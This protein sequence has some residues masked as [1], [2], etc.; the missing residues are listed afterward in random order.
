MFYLPIT[1][2]G[3]PFDL[4]RPPP[5][6]FLACWTSRFKEQCPNLQSPQG[7][8]QLWLFMGL[9]LVVVVLLVVWLGL[10]YWTYQTAKWAKFLSA[11]FLGLAGGYCGLAGG[12]CYSN[13]AKPKCTNFGSPF[14][15]TS[16]LWCISSEICLANDW[17]TEKKP[18]LKLRAR[19]WKLMVEQRSFPFGAWRIFRAEP[20]LV[21]GSL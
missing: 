2:I 1:G 20:I 19:P 17:N 16:S 10:L 15:W 18:S 13:K 8:K 14:F 12:Y 21:L 3:A 7:Y 9:L 11:N 6:S 4:P 5:N